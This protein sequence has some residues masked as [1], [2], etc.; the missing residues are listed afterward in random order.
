MKIFRQQLIEAKVAL[1]SL[2]MGG[3]ASILPYANAILMVIKEI[4][5]AIAM[6]FGIELKDYNS[7]IA[8]QEGIYDGVADSADNATKKAKELK[9]QILGFDEVHNIDENKGKNSDSSGTSGGIDQRLLDAI[10]GYDNGMDKVRMKA[11]QIRDRIMEWLGFTKKINPLTGETYFTYDG[12]DKTLSNVVKWWKNLNTETKIWTGLGVALGFVKLFNAM[13]KIAE[14]TGITPLFKTLFGVLTSGSIKMKNLVEYTKI[15]TALANGNL[16]KGIKGGTS[17]W[18]KQNSILTKSNVIIGMVVLGWTSFIKQYNN[19][20][21]FK[22]SVDA[23]FESINKLRV[24]QNIIKPL[25]GYL[26]K[27]L[28]SF[29]SV[30]DSTVS[31]F[32]EKISFPFKM[33]NK[34]IKADFK[35]ALKEAQDSYGTLVNNFKNSGTALLNLIPFVNIETEAQKFAKTMKKIEKEIFE[36]GGISIKEYKKSLDNL[37]SKIV[38]GLP[39]ISSYNQT[40]KDSKASYEGAKDSLAVL[41]TQMQTDAYEITADDIS[42]L[43]TILDTMT[44]SVKES[45]QAFTDATTAI[46][47]HLVEEG[48]ISEE[49]ALKVVQAAQM[50]AQAE[51]NRVEEYRLKLLELTNQYNSG[52]ISQEEFTKQQLELTKQFNTST[53]SIQIAKNSIK[54]YVDYINNEKLIS[55]KSWRELN[56]TIGEIGKSFSKNKKQ[57]EESYKSQKEILEESQLYWSNEI[58]KQNEVV[59]NLKRTKGE[60]SAEYQNAKSVLEDYK[61]NYNEVSNSIMEL[62]SQ[63]KDDIGNLKQTTVEALL[64]IVANLK[65]SGYSMKKDSD[66]TVKAINKQLKRLG[67]K[68]E[69]NLDQNISKIAKDIDSQLGTNA[70]NTV[71]KTNNK[72]SKIGRGVYPTVRVKANTDDADWKIRNWVNKITGTINAT[73]GVFGF[74]K[75]NGGVYSN[76]TWKNIPQYANGGSPSHGTMFVAGEAGAEIVGH[77]N[78]KTE[79]LNKSQIASAIYSAVYSAMSQFNGG[80]VAE[81][82]VHADEGIIVDTAINGINQKTRQTGVCPVD[83][84]IF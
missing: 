55:T 82:N 57:L 73:L 41:L 70:S 20:L 71:N 66:G 54:N 26:K 49:Q 68:D 1:S 25:G 21:K 67:I 19:N 69:V 64:G 8:S 80:G 48:K 51:N 35:G 79:V 7:G 81:I 30:I 2:F 58:K 9:R 28:T 40:I 78:G 52:K 12:I 74:R 15:Y 22:N 34:V 56:S 32:T 11:T 42:K 47:N 76:G 14:L 23:I 50:K 45:G 65:E 44:N 60:E 43:N 24:V 77:I 16:L 13:K 4:S 36:N 3:F 72:L 61:V 5:K 63:R 46:V 18:L 84:P 33:F 83:I 38:N 17:A 37:L 27:S 10:K 6:M 53:D 31:N 39:D 62:N 59:E 75:A 29:S